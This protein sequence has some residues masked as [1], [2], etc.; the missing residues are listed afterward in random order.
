[1][2]RPRFHEWA[3]GDV[4]RRTVCGQTGATSLRNTVSDLGN[5][6]SEDRCGNCERMRASIGT[7]SKAVSPEPPPVAAGSPL[8]ERLTAIALERRPLTER[9]LEIMMHATGWES[10]WPLYRNHFC[11]GP[12]H[13]AWLAIHGLI[14]IGLMRVSRAPSELSGGDTVFCVTAIGIAA[15][16]QKSRA[17]AA[18]EAA[19]QT[20]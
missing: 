1:M 13:D 8:E 12:G 19:K 14:G 18:G 15:L 5:V 7:S 6:A 16:K 4:A 9:E 20:G 11:A 3:W 10:R 2:Y 17:A